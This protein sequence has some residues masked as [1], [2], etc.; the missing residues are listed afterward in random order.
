MLFPSSEHVQLD[1]GLGVPLGNRRVSI[2]G[3]TLPLPAG[4]EGGR[5]L[6][7]GF[8]FDIAIVTTFAI[9]DME[10]PEPVLLFIT[11]AA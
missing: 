6:F 4:R 5:F 2:L 1:F 8:P 11:H 9:G 3:R 7:V 10:I